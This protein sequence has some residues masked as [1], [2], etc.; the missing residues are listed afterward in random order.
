YTQ[1]EY[2][3]H[4]EAV[5]IG[6]YCAAV[7]S[8]QQ[9]LPDMALAAQVETMLIQAGLPHKIPGFI[10]LDQLKELM[11]LDK[12]IKNNRL[13]F[14]VIKRPGDCYLDDGVTEECLHN[15]LITVV[16]GAQK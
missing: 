4:G 16:E 1:Y 7:L 9:G 15:T 10:E 14:V 12:K 5:A 11:R 3:L 13:R 2:W 6:L 8:S